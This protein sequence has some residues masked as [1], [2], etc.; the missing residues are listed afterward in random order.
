VKLTPTSG[1]F[2]FGREGFGRPL[3][4]STELYRSIQMMPEFIITLGVFLL[5]REK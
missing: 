2:F 5:M 1:L 3:T 4:I